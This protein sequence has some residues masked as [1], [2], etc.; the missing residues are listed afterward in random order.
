MS[1]K[2]KLSNS[3]WIP[4]LQY[5]LPIAQSWRLTES[6]K[7]C[8]LQ[9]RTDDYSSWSFGQ[10]W[11]QY[12]CQEFSLRINVYQQKTSLQMDITAAMLSLS[13]YRIILPYLCF[14]MIVFKCVL[15]V[16]TA[17]QSSPVCRMLYL[18]S[19]LECYQ[20]SLWR[21]IKLVNLT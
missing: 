4:H 17:L 8:V 1:V 15:F 21:Y 12:H 19:V 9:G 5:R 14:L 20:Y 13:L 3:P 18:W 10:C 2:W 11:I 7:L 6:V 16:T